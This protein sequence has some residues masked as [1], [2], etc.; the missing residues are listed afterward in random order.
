MTVRV[1]INGFGRIGRLVMRAILE[2]GRD[3]IQVVGINDLGSV[4]DNAFLLKRDSVHGTLANDIKVDG[5]TIRVG[6]QALTLR[7][8][9]FVLSVFQP[10]SRTR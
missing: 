4:E 2:N 5:S 10:A 8:G 1:G 6:K 3:D 7:G 9:Q